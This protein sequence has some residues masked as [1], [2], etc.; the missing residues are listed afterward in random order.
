MKNLKIKTGLLAF[1]FGLA[2]VFSQS[3][4]KYVNNGGKAVASRT[5]Y[6][7]GPNTY[8]QAQVEDESNWSI[9][10]P[11]DL[12][13]NVNQAACEIIVDE[14]FVDN[15]S[16]PTPTLKSSLNLVSSYNSGT[17][18]AYITSSDDPS[19]TLENRTK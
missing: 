17:S 13:N 1:V 16:T 4:F 12:C 3:A 6:Y 18:S 19:M 7:H 10:P 14:N 15:P 11:E 2:I 5:F 9:A 8:T